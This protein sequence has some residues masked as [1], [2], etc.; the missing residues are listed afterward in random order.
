MYA[1]HL[2]SRRRFLQTASSGFGMMALTGM[3]SASRGD[4]P[5]PAGRAKHVILCYMS[6]GVSHIDTFDP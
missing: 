4:A 1:D 5:A 2:S 3:L 6:G